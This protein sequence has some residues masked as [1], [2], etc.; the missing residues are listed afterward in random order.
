MNSVHERR[1]WLW[2]SKYGS[3]I[4]EKGSLE[5]ESP[6][7]FESPLVFVSETG[8]TSPRGLTGF[9][10]SENAFCMAATVLSMTVS[11][12][13]DS[14]S[15]NSIVLMGLM[16]SSAWGAPSALACLCDSRYAEF[17]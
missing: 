17:A 1:T 3:N 6:L 4:L 12:V 14:T 13:A 7:A 11:L 9:V 5:T 8:P 10:T 16:K 15:R 2:S